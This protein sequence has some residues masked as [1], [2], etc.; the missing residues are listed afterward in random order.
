[1]G[2]RM[3]GYTGTMHVCVS[4]TGQKVLEVYR[5]LS[6]VTQTASTPHS[7]AQ[8]LKEANLF[9]YVILQ[10]VQDTCCGL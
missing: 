3:K 2:E 1:M 5:E 7:G 6:Y 4:R 8:A 10:Q 9:M